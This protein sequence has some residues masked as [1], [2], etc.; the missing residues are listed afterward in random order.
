MAYL[1][2]TAGKDRKE[3]TETIRKKY[4]GDNKPFEAAMRGK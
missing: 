2:K 4:K 1:M 3:L